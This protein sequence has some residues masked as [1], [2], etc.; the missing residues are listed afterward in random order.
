MSPRWVL[1]HAFNLPVGS[2]FV[3]EQRGGP[4][5][6]GWD[7]TRYMIAS[8]YNVINILKYITILANRNPDAPEIE[9]PEPYPLPDD[10]SV[11]RPK[12]DK[13]GSFGFIAR[14]LLAKAKKR[15]AGGS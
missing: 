8:V 7:E 12:A 13:P 15:K 1:M 6:R 14:S 3:A 5:F 4:Q 11:K 9:L 2:A 10:L